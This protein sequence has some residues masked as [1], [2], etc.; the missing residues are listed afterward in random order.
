MLYLIAILATN[1]VQDAVFRFYSMYSALKM[2]VTI[3]GQGQVDK[4]GIRSY[5]LLPIASCHVYREL[6]S[7]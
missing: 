3:Q 7:I 5:L 1:K 6:L 2:L 4:T